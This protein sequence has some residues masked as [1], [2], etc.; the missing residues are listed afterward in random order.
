MSA[1]KQI[2]EPKPTVDRAGVKVQRGSG[3]AACMT[4][5]M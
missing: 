4:G 3:K 5:Q 2:I 1:V